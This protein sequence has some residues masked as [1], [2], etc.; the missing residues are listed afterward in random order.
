MKRLLVA[1]VM[2]IMLLNGTFA[3]AEAALGES[4]ALRA[5][6][7]YLESIPFS[8]DGL[9][10]QLEYDGYST[11]E[12]TYAAD[13]C[14]ADWYQQ[15][16]LSAKNY[17]DIMAFSRS[18]LIEQL[19]YDGFT[20]DQAIYGVEQNG[21]SDGSTESATKESMVSASVDNS[22]TEYLCFPF[23][24]DEGM[25]A[26]N[27]LCKSLFDDGTLS[28][29]YSVKESFASKVGN[30]YSISRDGAFIDSVLTFDKE[31]STGAIYCITTSYSDTS[32]AVTSDDKTNIVM[33][34]MMFADNTLTFSDANALGVSVMKSNG[35]TFVQNGFEYTYDGNHIWEIR[36]LN[37]S[38][39]PK[40][41]EEPVQADD[42]DN[43]VDVVAPTHLNGMG[44]TADTWCAVDVSR[45]Y[46]ML[47]M[48][49]DCLDVWTDEEMT[50]VAEAINYDTIYMVEDDEDVSVWLY[51][52]NALMVFLYDTETGNAYYQVTDVNDVY[53]KADEYM[54][55]LENNGDIPLF[56]PIDSDAVMELMDTHS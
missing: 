1:I 12:A 30:T 34:S 20:H 26:F 7:S 54:E 6:E 45:N 31:E 18:G 28:V 55:A 15:A 40:H 35:N 38:Y 43:C 50:L 46:F 4:N 21:Y 44:L 47:C 13:N 27:T 32:K 56:I 52:K 16:V 48:I 37:S 25:N 11:A 41:T 23:S 51:G 33:L 24:C 9:I 42:N 8:H 5:A 10:A 36:R 22:A 19:E 3:L 2:I 49:M 17:L 14:K 29:L 39:T 53:T